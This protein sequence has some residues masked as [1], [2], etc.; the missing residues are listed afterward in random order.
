MEPF[1]YNDL[2]VLHDLAKILASP[3]D[4]RDQLEQ[5]LNELCTRT[6]MN[7]GMISIL[8][9]DTGIAILDVA[10]GVDID[11]REIIYKPGEGITG[12]VAQTGKPLVITNLDE[13]KHFLDRTGSRRSLNRSELTFFCVPI[14]HDDKV[15]G[16]LSADKAAMEADNQEYELKL[17]CEVAELIAK[18]VNMR[19]LEE[20]NIMLR[21]VLKKSRRPSEELVG[22]S[23]TMKDVSGLIFQVSESDTTVLIHGE[24]GTGKELVA[25]A[26]HM[27][28]DRKSVV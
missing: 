17:L 18:A 27:N 10:Y 6:A 14:I 23:K 12:Q 24:T 13:E 8:D 25:R 19:V 21:N 11:S 2:G 16:V 20:E 26:I 15:V 9:R 7:R 28:R 5:G 4:L 1:T 22:N 3:L